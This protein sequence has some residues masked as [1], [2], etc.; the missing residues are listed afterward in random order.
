MSLGAAQYYLMS[1]SQCFIAAVSL[2]V[3]D[4]ICQDLLVCHLS[5]ISAKIVNVSRL[6]LMVN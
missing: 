5:D 1:L 3:D 4:N 6:V 2:A